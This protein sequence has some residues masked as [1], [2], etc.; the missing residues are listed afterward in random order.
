MSKFNF[1]QVKGQRKYRKWDEYAEGDILICKLRDTYQDK[2]RNNCYEVEV[3]ESDF[4]DGENFKEGDIV[5][6]NSMGSLHYK[7]EDVPLG[8]V[9]RIEYTGKT[10]LEKGP[11]E[12]K[13]A[14]T[15]SVAVDENSI[16]SEAE[17]IKKV[18]DEQKAQ[19]ESSEEEADYDL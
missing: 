14:H 15:C 9:V 5:G 4:Q 6:L 13:E 3:I 8:A 10:T 17:S 16:G 1:K 19:Q 2:F 12:G 18:Q 7:L 11:Y